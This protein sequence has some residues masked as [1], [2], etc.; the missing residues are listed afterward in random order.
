[1][2][3]PEPLALR[4]APSGGGA[5]RGASEASELGA[6][7]HR[8]GR[9]SSRTFL[10]PG[11]RSEPGKGRGGLGAA[12]REGRWYQPSLPSVPDGSGGRGD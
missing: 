3:V 11:L 9:T 10:W 12:G 6:E 2:P 8:G 7:S 1:M 5:T 4:E